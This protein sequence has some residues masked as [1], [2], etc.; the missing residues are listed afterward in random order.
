M[1]QSS[2]KNVTLL[3]PIFDQP[4]ERLYFRRVFG[5]ERRYR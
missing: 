3:G 5:D 2:L 4:L 1:V